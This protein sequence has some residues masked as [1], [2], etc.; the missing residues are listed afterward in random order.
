VASTSS[1]RSIAIAMQSKPGPMLAIEAGTLIRT[2]DPL[3]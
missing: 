3:P 1:H 2:I